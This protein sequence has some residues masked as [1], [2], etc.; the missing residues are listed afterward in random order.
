MI[1]KAD[2]I[3]NIPL[4]IIAAT[5]LLILI[6]EAIFPH[7]KKKIGEKI[8]FYLSIV[9]LIVAINYSF[10]QLTVNSL[11]FSSFLRLS[12]FSVVVNITMLLGILITVLSSKEYLEKEGI[13]YGEYY[14]LLFIATL[15]MMLMVM[16]YDLIIVF[17]GLEI[18][19]ISFYVLAGFMR[20]R[21]ESNES[22]LKYFLLGAFFTGFLLMGI[23]LIYG[24][25]GS[26]SYSF[27]TNFKNQTEPTYFLGIVLI[28]IAF[29]FK[30]GSFPLQMW[31]P[32]VYQ[33]APTVVTGMMSSVGK[34]AAFGALLVF[35]TTF[36]LE[37]FSMLIAILAILT[38]LYGNV[39]ALLQTNIKRLLAY[40]SIAHAG[41]I[42]IGFILVTPS[43][44]HAV[45]FYLVSYVLMQLGAFIVIG[46]VEAQADT[47]EDRSLSNTL[48]SYKGLGKTN[49]GLASI[50]SI[51]LFS[52][53]GIPPFAG[54]WGKYYIFLSVIQN[55]F[56]WV[57]IVGI[58]LSLIGVYYYIKVILFMWFYEPVTGTIQK[59]KSEFAFTAAVI[60][61]I[62]LFLFGIYPDLLL[63]YIRA[64]F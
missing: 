9:S 37:K 43:S 34:T 19:S 56:I 22:A 11:F 25:T 12:T 45:V 54:F 15:G 63:R 61:T 21:L 40:S 47:M 52:L 48:E 36:G 33:G 5:S 3:N 46:I 60:S 16:A 64:I 4:L 59:S 1:N 28:L 6:I 26:T 30:T 31:I 2:F 10:P 42:L 53:A 8:I 29:I 27:F 51:F 20:K 7:G 39:V 14:S 41:Y 24:Y 17:V 55:N 50:L 57:A 23:A 13:N 35:F 58:L 18:M 32:D 49:P 44:T 38:M 62:G